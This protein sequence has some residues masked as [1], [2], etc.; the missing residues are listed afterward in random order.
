MA[1]L[2][3]PVITI[4]SED[5]TVVSHSV[6]VALGSP[7]NPMAAAALRAKF[8]ALAAVALPLAQADALA[9]QVL[10]LDEVDDARVLLSLLV[11]RSEQHALIC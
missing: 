7:G 1:A 4:T 8:Q 5:G 3:E 10:H 6:P 9:D 11:G 2:D